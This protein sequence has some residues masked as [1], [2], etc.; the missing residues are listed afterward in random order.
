MRPGPSRPVTLTDRE[1]DH[2][3]AV[4]R[5]QASEV[6]KLRQEM[7]HAARARQATLLLLHDAGLSVRRIAAEL[8]VS[9]A[10]VAH[11]LTAARAPHGGPV[12]VP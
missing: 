9:H 4:A 7:L 12:A 6:E 8:D 10:V 11:A 1:R 3:L 2:L 5:T